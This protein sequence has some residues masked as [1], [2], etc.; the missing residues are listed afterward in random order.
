MIRRRKF[1][2]GLGVAAATWPFAARAQQPERMRRIG[3]LLSQ[4]ESDPVAQSYV[5]AFAT[6]LR[7]LGWAEGK[8]LHT[9]YRWGGGNTT[10]MPPLAKELVGLQPNALLAAT[11]VSAVHLRQY[12]LTI[13]IV[14]TQVGDPVALGLVS[15]LARPNGNITGFTSFDYSIGGKWLQALKECAPSLKRVAVFFEAGNPSSVQYVTAIEAAAASVGVGLVSSPVQD[16]IEIAQAFASFAAQAI[17]A[18][19]AVPTAGVVRHREQIIALAAKYRLPAMYP[20][21]FFAAEGGLISYG[22][23]MANQ[24]RQA[25]LYIDRILKGEKPADLPVQQPTKFELI[26]NLKT[27]QALGLTLPTGL[28][29]RADEVIE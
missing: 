8:N 9:D 16:A 26:I 15:S 14:F 17:G 2:A 24:F 20:Y 25:A 18:V 10:H 13:P 11:A 22:T 21:R 1:I 3:V 23:D 7:E 5:S 6:R 29:V 12:T 28:F 4:A 19:I 27:A